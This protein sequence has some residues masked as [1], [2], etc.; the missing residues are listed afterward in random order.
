M[1][2]VH[3]NTTTIEMSSITPNYGWDYFSIESTP[4]I[5]QLFRN[6]SVSSL[7]LKFSGLVPGSQYRFTISVT[8]STSCEVGTNHP[9]S[10]VAAAC[11]GRH[12]LFSEKKGLEKIT[13]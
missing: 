10:M 2:L 4:Q 11:T 6:E 1:A 7:P 8:I 5:A 9:T 12:S 13:K 3:I